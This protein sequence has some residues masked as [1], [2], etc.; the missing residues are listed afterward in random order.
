MGAKTFFS[1]PAKFAAVGREWSE[2]F[3]EPFLET[4]GEVTEPPK[5]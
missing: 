4:G 1:M 5:V 3:L 2:P